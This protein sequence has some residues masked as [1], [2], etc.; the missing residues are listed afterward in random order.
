MLTLICAPCCSEMFSWPEN[1]KISPV[2]QRSPQKTF[3]PMRKLLLSTLLLCLF[4]NLLSAQNPAKLTNVFDLKDALAKKLVSIQIEG[5]GGHQGESIK[6]VCKNL[7]GQYLRLRI[8]Q[9]QLMEPVDSA[10]QTLVVAEEMLLAVTAKTP[11][12][13]S[14]KTFCTQAGDNSPSAGSAFSVGAIAPT[15]VCNL[16]KFIT[17]KGKT[18]SSEAQTAVWCL[19]SGKSLASIG[20]EELIKFVADQLGKEVP[21]YKIRH[22]VVETVPGRPAELGKALVVEGNFRYYLEKDERTVMVLLDGSGKLIKQ[23]GK[24]EIMKAGE[25]RSSLRLEVYNLDPGKYTLRMQ[26][27]AGRVIKDTE[28]EF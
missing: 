18:E 13:G 16:L 11:V 20:D 12:E 21:G 22:S 17:E 2:A 6:I 3:Y 5:K 8:P 26:T 9:G 19:T 14:L 28:I 7:R 1:Q 23:V 27:K 25:H 10:Q 24:E 4:S 15:M